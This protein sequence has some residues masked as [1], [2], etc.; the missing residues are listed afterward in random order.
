MKRIL[1]AG[2]L[3]L[4]TSVPSLAADLPPAPPPPPRAPAAYVPAA[5]AF[6]WTGF[7]VGL[8]A[9]YG[10]GQTKW[11]TAFGT[12]GNFSTNGPL[13]GGTIGGNY[14]WGQLVL[15][16]EGDIDWQNLRGATATQPCTSVVIAVI[17]IGIG[18]CATASNWIA[19]IRGRVGVAMDHALLYG[20]FGGAFTNIK[21]STGALAYGGGSEPGWAAGGGVEYAVTGNWS[22]KLEYLYAGFQRTT[23]NVGSCGILGAIPAPVRFTEGMVRVGANYKFGY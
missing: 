14:Q 13:A 16:V 22:A 12:V 15:G 1:L 19:T 9:G 20:T 5:P 4:A 6:S 23:C 2:A 10:F 17:P 8:N 7:Y 11:N 21:P 3:A 18:G